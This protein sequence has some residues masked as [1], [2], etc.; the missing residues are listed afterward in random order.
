MM[1][2]QI[3]KQQIAVIAVTMHPSLTVG[4]ITGIFQAQIAT[5][6]RAIMMHNLFQHYH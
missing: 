6:V 4:D 2:V 3:D 5:K 1:I